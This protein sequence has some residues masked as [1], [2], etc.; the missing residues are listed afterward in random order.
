MQNAAYALLQK[1]I[2]IK[3]ALRDYEEHFYNQLI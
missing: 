2:Y 1:S 3:N